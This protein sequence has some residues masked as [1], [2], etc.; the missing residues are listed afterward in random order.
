MCTLMLLDLHFTR[1]ASVSPSLAMNVHVGDGVSGMG[2]L[3]WLS[4]K[5]IVPV[6]DQTFLCNYPLHVYV[7]CGECYQY[8]A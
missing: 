6:Y 2:Q 5:L 7:E 8:I 1:S 3:D 4:S